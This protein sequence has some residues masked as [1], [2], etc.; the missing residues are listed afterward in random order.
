MKMMGKE[1]LLVL[2]QNP[3][4]D[5]YNDFRL[6]FL[7][8]KY[9]VAIDYVYT[10]FKPSFGIRLAALFLCG[11]CT[12][13]RKNGVM[14]IVNGL[15]S[16]LFAIIRKMLGPKNYLQ[17]MTSIFNENWAQ[18]LYQKLRPSVLVFDWV[19]MEQHVTGALLNAAKKL[20][21]PTISVPHG[22]S[23]IVSNL[24]REKEIRQ[25]YPES[26]AERYGLFDYFI[27]Q[28]GQYKNYCTRNGMSEEK[29]VVLGSARYCEEWRGVYNEIAPKWEGVHV[30]DED[31]LKVVF[32]EYPYNYRIHKKIVLES[33]KKL[34]QLDFVYMVIKPHTRSNRIYAEEL[35]SRGYIAYDVPSVK[36]CKWADV[37]IGTTSSILLE[38]LLNGKVLLYPKY[39]H[40][41]AMLYETM[42][43]SWVVGN[44]EELED[45]MRKVNE[46]RRYKPYS[47]ENVQALITEVVKGGDSGRDVLSDYVDFIEQSAIK[48]AD[49]AKR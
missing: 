20:C 37:V 2:C 12:R 29:I 8:K 46:D 38:P 33:I 49:G 45:A 34:A 48:V 15:H 36:L 30:Q 11:P 13:K 28:H 18:R 25:G 1:K 31:K 35:L 40:D 32:M 23:L 44:Y 10:Y 24:Q 27:V 6:D 3:N 17:V 41:N 26:F 9:N 39:F 21:I 19:K 42:K 16:F 47:A 14:R 4:Y 22:L 5:I 43:A 7:S